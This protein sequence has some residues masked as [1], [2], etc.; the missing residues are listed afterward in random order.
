MTQ[1]QK[2]LVYFLGNGS[3]SDRR[4]VDDQ[5][6]RKIGPTSGEFLEIAKL[7]RM[8]SFSAFSILRVKLTRLKAKERINERLSSRT[9][10]AVDRRS[11]HRCHRFT[12][13]LLDGD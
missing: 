4:W 10:R 11:Q 13:T 7:S 1:T 6:S 3:G 2:L 9:N 8:G 5:P 12:R